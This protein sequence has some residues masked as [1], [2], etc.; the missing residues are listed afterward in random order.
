MFD[1]EIVDAEIVDADAP[2]PWIQNAAREAAEQIAEVKAEF[3]DAAQREAELAA[4]PGAETFD[5]RVRREQPYANAAIKIRQA[6]EEIPLHM[7]PADL[8][9]RVPDYSE[10]NVNRLPEALAWLVAF[11]NAYR[12]RRVVVA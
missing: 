7:D 3:D 6:I 8:A 4:M 1:D 12:D 9:S 11:N 5:Q 2:A 10:H